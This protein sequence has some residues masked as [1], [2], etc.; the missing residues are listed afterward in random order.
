MH[1]LGLLFLG[2]LV[3]LLPL[4][5]LFPRARWRLR[6]RMLAFLA[7]FAAFVGL[8][9][10]NHQTPEPGSPPS[11]I[12][13]CGSEAVTRCAPQALPA[14][15]TCLSNP[16]D[17]QACLIGLIPTVACGSEAIL[18]CVVRDVGSKAS[19]SAQINPADTVSARQA[20]R[21]RE[22]IASR[23]YTFGP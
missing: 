17:W 15:N 11:G 12:I 13:A 3:A 10:C 6:P 18:A 21:A 14:V 1:N 8:P 9:A 20:Q 7:L 22:W 16:G 23:G 2:V 19:A 5:V 4:I